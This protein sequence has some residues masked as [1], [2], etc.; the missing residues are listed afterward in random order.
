VWTA[1]NF[2]MHDS[3]HPQIEKIFWNIFPKYIDGYII[4]SNYANNILKEKHREFA[5]INHS[6][7]Y[8]GHYKEWYDNSISRDEA[9]SHLEIDEGCF[10]FL[11]IGSI[12]PYKNISTLLNAFDDLKN[13]KNKLVI[14]GKSNS[15]TLDNQ[16]HDC[17]N[18]NPDLIYHSKWVDDE[19]FQVYFNAADLAVLPYNIPSSGMALLSLSFGCPIL[20]PKNPMLEEY[21]EIVSDNQLYLYDGILTSNILKVVKDELLANKTSEINDIDNLEVLDWYNLADKT[22]QFYSELLKQ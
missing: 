19:E 18:K 6:I 9:K 13:G 21:R 14:A 10:V 20:M 17:T 16:I 11:F 3:L 12:R 2:E 7:I 5:K 8:H 1:H 15:V 4:H 22:K